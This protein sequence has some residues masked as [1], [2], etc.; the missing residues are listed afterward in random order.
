MTANY[1]RV[2][3]GLVKALELIPATVLNMESLNETREINANTVQAIRS[4]LPEIE[5]V[6]QFDQNIP[7]PQGS[8][9]VRIR[10]YKPTDQSENLPGLLWIH[11]GGYVMG[12]IDGDD[13]PCKLR[14]K[15]VGCIVVSVDY[16]LAPENPYPAPLE[17]CYAA[18]K[19]MTD[20]ADELGL[21]KTRIAIGGGS[22]GGGLT[23][24]LALLVRDRAELDIVFQML[25]YPM[26]DDCNIAPADEHHP[27]TLI[28]SREKNLFGWTSY[29][30]RQPGGSD[31]SPYAAAFREKN[32]AGLPPALIVVGDLDLFINENIEYAKRLIHCRVPT[33]L[34]VYTG[35]YHGF[36]GFAPGAAIS[37]ECNGACHNALKKALF[38]A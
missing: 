11:G 1:D 12:G 22:A 15:K 20:H 25:I 36:N 7:G 35:A 17:D 28:W 4:L 13:Y 37:R 32:L 29:L 38:T 10:I 2:D 34:H 16:R 5:N 19:W 18:L 3:P 26:I 31:V 8:P 9:D 27:D 30:G 23:A 24:A 33:E 14:V 21:D 6:R